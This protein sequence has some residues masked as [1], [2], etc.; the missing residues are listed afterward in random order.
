MRVDLKEFRAAYLAEVDEHLS[1]VNQRRATK[2]VPGSP[3]AGGRHRDASTV[4]CENS[5]VP[6]HS[7]SSRMAESPV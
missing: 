6:S 5:G 7:V 4:I 3:A 2:I 1:G